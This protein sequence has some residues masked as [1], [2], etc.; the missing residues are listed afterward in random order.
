[1]L[2]RSD[3]HVQKRYQV[4]LRE[5]VPDG[6]AL[7]ACMREIGKR[8]RKFETQI[9]TTGEAAS[10]APAAVVENADNAEVSA[11]AGEIAEEA[12]EAPA[13][14]AIDW[15]RIESIVRELDTRLASMGPVNLDA[16]AEFEELEQRHAFQIGRA[17]V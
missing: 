8:I 13:V 6:Y 9:E 11:E 10:E 14:A 7:A 5:F 12:T 16:I 17:H 3:D 4:T 1:M 2:F 15:A